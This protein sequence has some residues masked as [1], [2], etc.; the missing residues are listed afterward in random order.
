[1]INR[2][3]HP[4]GT[5]EF[6]SDIVTADSAKGIMFALLIPLDPTGFAALLDH[7]TRPESD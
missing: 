6:V 4:A 2:L 1:M 3:Y 7:H 5:L